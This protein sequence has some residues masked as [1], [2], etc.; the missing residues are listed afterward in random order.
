MTGR[1]D[2]RSA[3]RRRTASPGL[4]GRRGSDT[5]HAPVPRARHARR[6]RRPRPAEARP[7][8]WP[9]AA[10]P[11]PRRPRW[12]IRSDRRA[13]ARGRPS[14]RRAARATSHRTGLRRR[15]PASARFSWPSRRRQS[16]R[17]FGG[18]RRANGFIAGKAPRLYPAPLGL[19]RRAGPASRSGSWLRRGADSPGRRKFIERRRGTAGTRRV[20]WRS[21]IA[22]R[23]SVASTGSSPN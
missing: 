5:G 11:G 4:R 3:R 1:W 17:W 8:P 18:S 7:R 12:P 14:S 16:R 21:R 9:R 15:G 23:Q 2:T 19:E 10:R 6:L 20:V 22:P 13:R